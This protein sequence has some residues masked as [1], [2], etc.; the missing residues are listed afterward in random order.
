MKNPL[1]KK[2]LMTGARVAGYVGAGAIAAQLGSHAVKRLSTGAAT[3]AAKSPYN[4]AAV[5]L[6]AGLLGAALAFM[7]ASK[8]KMKGAAGAAALFA[9]GAG[10]SA[11]APIAKVEIVDRISA[12]LDKALP[13][14][15]APAGYFGRASSY[16]VG[17]GS[18][19][20]VAEVYDIPRR[21]GGIA[22]YD[23]PFTG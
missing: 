14:S 6:G 17:G 7:V 12:A 4:E 9:A 16:E 19:V 8:L 21:A 15:A 1:N 20:D 22:S 10:L 5:D 3:F 11:V 23:V 13:A 2:V 18:S